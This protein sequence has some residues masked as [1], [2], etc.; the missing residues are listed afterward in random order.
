MEQLQQI[1]AE[2]NLSIRPGDILFIRVGFT[3]AY[4]ALDLAE[5]KAIACRP[6]PDF[7]GVESSCS[8]LRWIW[9]SGFAAVASDAPSFEQSPWQEKNWD[10]DMRGGGL[11]HQWLLGGCGLAD[12]PAKCLTSRS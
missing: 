9:E 8:M 2:D 7:L 12:W 4:E 11:L 3:A 10:E 6:S 1:V 5:Q